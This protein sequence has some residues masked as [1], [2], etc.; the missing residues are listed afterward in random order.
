MARLVCVNAWG[1][2]ILQPFLQYL[3][4]ADADIYCIQEVLDSPM[5]W[6]DE[7]Y[8]PN[9]LDK[10]Q[11]VLPDHN[12]YY[13]PFCDDFFF[14]RPIQATVTFGIATAVRRSLMVGKVE[15]HFVFLQR[16]GPPFAPR[17]VDVPRG[18]Q[19]VEL[20]QHGIWIM[21]FHGLVTGSPYKGDSPLLLEQSR[22]I[23]ALMEGKRVI[24]AGDFNI[25]AHCESMRIL[26][27]GMSNLIIE[28]GITSTRN[29]YWK[30]EDKYS[31][32]ILVPEDLAIEKFSVADT[33]V[34]DHLPLELAFM[35]PSSAQR[36]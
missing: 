18:V 35:L 27:A 10:I 13:M 1:G 8:C 28:G 19:M 20:P 4:E 25:T 6:E 21:N 26:D 5:Q 23:R 33:E 7:L 14:D 16:H 29:H 17:G 2:R 9:L 11:E 32:Y 34:S 3:K 31:D 15:D 24:L 36:S 30:H 12:V 22:R